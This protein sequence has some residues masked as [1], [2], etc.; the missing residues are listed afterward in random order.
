MKQSS[1]LFLL[2]FSFPTLAQENSSDS[3]F[4]H[5]EAQTAATP[6]I[7]AQT[8][9]LIEQRCNA[10]AQH[11]HLE[12]GLQENAPTTLLNWPLKAAANL[13]D[14]SFYVISAYVDQNTTAGMTSD[15]NCGARTYDGHRGT[16]IATTPFGFYK[17]DSSQVEVIAAAPGVIIDKNDGQFD[18]NC[19]V[20]NLPANYV[21]LQHTDGSR[22]L[23]W[24]MKKNSVTSKAIGQSVATGEYLG[25]VGSSGS[26]SGPHLHFEVW[27]GNNNSTRVDPYSGN[28]NSLN[29]SSW[30]VEQKPYTEPAVIKSSVHTTDIVVPGCPNTETTN[31][32]TCFTIPFQG[33]GLPA[34]SAKFYI[35]MRN[36]TP[37]LVAQVSIL[38]PDGSTFNS[39]THNSTNSYNA[40]W[41]A[42]T[43]PLPIIGGIYTFQAVYN[44]QTSSS[45]FEIV[46]PA[47]TANGPTTVCA[48]TQV[49]LTA[50]GGTSYVWSNG[51]STATIQVGTSGSY[52]VTATGA[53]GCTA[54]S[55]ATTVTVLAAPTASITANGSTTVCAGTQV[56]LTASGG[57]S[58]V[59]SN[60]ASTATIQVGTSGSYQVTATGANGCTAVSAAT[61]VTVLPLPTA[62]ITP[63]G[64][65]MVCSGATVSLTASGGTSY[66]WSNGASTATIQVGT[67]GSYQVT[68]TGANSCTAVSMPTV[69]MINPLPAIPAISADGNLLTSSASEG[70]QWF[71]NGNPI[72]GATEA[73][74]QA[75]ES[76]VYTVQ[77]TDANNCVSE[78]AGFNYAS[79]GI[80]PVTADEA[81]IIAPN[82]NEGLFYIET[83][84]QTI[85]TVEIYTASGV[86]VDVHIDPFSKLGEL[87][88]RALPS[89]VYMVCITTS[90]MRSIK[91]V[92][93]Y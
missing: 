90:Q 82:P 6:C 20:N 48:G 13:H 24:H 12:N 50:S 21:I 8:Y 58:Y 71:L 75:N 35:F 44:G 87:D 59:W 46:K 51:A 22:T 36:E 85:S 54:V 73:T 72:P 5:F 92:F 43:K 1:L 77:V 14:Y 69:V 65:T 18:R 32:S 80:N 56:S 47:I 42:W 89:G 79:T 53:N 40:S 41:R 60:G 4:F 28:C 34:G 55:S 93:K 81:W 76:G 17:L 62:T 9:A 57:T 2:L 64:P 23:Y 67:S 15:Y 26:S 39:W 66:V 38:N 33:P 3:G 70:N 74:Y 78:S 83:S 16:D 11:L 10:N 91:K 45:T 27:A 25:V 84:F 7:S 52:Q 49:S 86:P 88:I 19:G 68:A 29:G 63:N 61:T 31:E 30:W 37:G